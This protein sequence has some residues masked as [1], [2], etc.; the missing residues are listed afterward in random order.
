MKHFLAIALVLMVAGFAFAQ[1]TPGPIVSRTMQVQK[2]TIPS[3]AIV[4]AA[5]TCDVTVTT[6][7]PKVFLV[8]TIADLTTTFACTA[9]CT[10]STLSAVLGKTAGGNQYLVS[11]DADAATS[12]FGDAAAELGASLTGATVATEMGDLG[13]W[14]TTTTVTMR[15]TSGTGN[16]GNA[17]VTNL[18]QG[19]VTI[20]FI[21]IT[22]P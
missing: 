10:T 21:T 15:F 1:V 17:S 5:V 6:L 9:V 7:G 8:D 22:L 3:S 20:Y 13:S 19:S 14:T 12:Q 11:F 4:C 16:F 18:S 2:V